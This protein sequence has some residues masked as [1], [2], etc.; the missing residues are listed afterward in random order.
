MTSPGDPRATR[1]AE[2]GL[3]PGSRCLRCRAERPLP[4]AW[5]FWKN[6]PTMDKGVVEDW[7]SEFKALPES[8]ISSYAVTVHQKTALVS[9]LYKVI[10]A[11]NS[12][13]LEPVCHQ[14]FE[15]VRSGE[16][17]L[18][19][20]ALQFLPALISRYLAGSAPY[21]LRVQSHG[22]VDALLLG[23]YN[24]E[25]V[26][27]DGNSK[28][29]AFTIPT[30]AKP[31]LYHEPG[32]LGSMAMM[33]AVLSGREAVRVAY[34]G[35]LPQ[36][37]AFTAQNRFEVL[38]FLM[39]CYNAAIAHMPP[40]SHQALCHMCSRV[41]VS[42]FPRQKKRWR[43]HRTK[44][45]LSPE[46]IVDLL[47]GVYYSI[48]NGQWEL[49]Q[50][51]LDDVL[52]RAQLELYTEPLLVGN[53]MRSSL[54]NSTPETI[55]QGQ[56]CI[57]VDVT[58]TF[59]RL[60]RGAVTSASIRR[61][62]WRKDVLEEQS[63]EDSLQVVEA[64]EGFSSL[65][66]TSSHSASASTS[67]SFA[68]KSSTRKVEIVSN[69]VGRGEK[70]SKGKIKN[71]PLASRHDTKPAITDLVADSISHFKGL[72]EKDEH[73]PLLG[74]TAAAGQT[75]KCFPPLAG[76]GSSP[77]SKS[78]A[79]EAATETSYLQQDSISGTADTE[80]QRVNPSLSMSTLK[81]R[82]FSL[83]SESAAIHSC[84]HNLSGANASD[85][86]LRATDDM[87]EGSSEMNTENV[88]LLS[89]SSLQDVSLELVEFS[90]SH[91]LNQ[92]ARSPSLNA[93]LIT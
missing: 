67:K 10:G 75:R 85:P 40:S 12:E 43:E 58:P 84:E 9:A 1:G 70:G 45:S 66:S 57:Q 64:D 14:L 35:P 79:S 50:E 53:A 33:E 80:T 88:G 29:L 52:Y 26:E 81:P 32:S 39:L 36:R 48:Y 56:Q 69:W 22:C 62:R 18:R 76:H 68:Q 34:A 8:S 47:T 51:A 15:F 71:S 59:R 63:T 82:E 30:L 73:L 46:F 19:H 28:V 61:H 23:L 87:Q 89:S 13:L 74:L 5:G 11:L 20:F 77:H 72:G 54:K 21:G 78:D 7:L 55:H 49:G 17:R 42:G 86:L 92:Q 25:I 90:P 16:A 6:V 65:A 91:Q 27:A 41:C 2:F 3:I 24:L 4:R 38:S 44:I 37:E 83:S 93:H 31:S 60:S